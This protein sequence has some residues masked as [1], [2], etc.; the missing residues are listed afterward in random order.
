MSFRGY[1][2]KVASRPSWWTRNYS[3]WRHDMFS[4]QVKSSS[5][6]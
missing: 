4:S 6:T 2:I 1:M 5:F 3:K